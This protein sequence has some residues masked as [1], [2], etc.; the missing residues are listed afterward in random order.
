[1]GSI[2]WGLAISEPSALVNAAA[3]S[4]AGKRYFTMTGNR[5]NGVHVTDI[6]AAASLGL[7]LYPKPGTKT[8][9]KKARK[10]S[11]TTTALEPLGSRNDYLSL[12]AYR[13]RKKGHSIEQIT[14]MLKVMAQHFCDQSVDPMSD[15]EIEAIARGKANI[16]PEAVPDGPVAE[17]LTL[18]EMLQRFVHIASG[19]IIV[20]ITDPRRVFRP[21]E[22]RSHYSASRIV[23]EDKQ[24]AISGLWL[25]HKNRMSA[26]MR[27]FDPRHGQFF[28]DKGRQVFNSWTPPSWPQADIALADPFFEHIDYM[29]PDEKE[30]RDFLDWLA[31][32]V[33]APW[34][35]GHPGHT[36]RTHPSA[37]YGRRE[38]P[39]CAPLGCGR[40]RQ[41]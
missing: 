10:A 28:E 36:G 38:T 12:E 40:H 2:S 17:L 26:D 13:W 30:R 24:V 11:A 8:N 31:H 22:F 34:R 3:L 5:L 29:I 37:L 21:G 1:M 35:H 27:T 18:E 4:C 33:Q 9:P 6:R 20:D 41:Q 25:K 14:A 15:A 7:E 39:T 19:P 23:T 16:E 32:M